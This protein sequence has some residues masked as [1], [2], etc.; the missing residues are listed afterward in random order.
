M[1]EK[2]LSQIASLLGGEVQGDGS[3][4]ICGVA[5]IEQAKPGDL[6]FVANPRYKKLLKT[7]KA[8]AAIVG[9]D[10]EKSPIPLIRHPNPYF[11]F[12]K[13]I[14]IFFDYQ[15]TYPEKIDPTCIQGKNLKLGKGVFIGPFVVL[16]DDVE[17][18]DKVV[19]LAS[20]YIGDGVLI[21][22]NSFIYPNVT[23][24]EGSVIGKDV[25][26]H[27]GAVI[28]SDGFGYAK[29]G[30]IYHKIPQ[31]GKVVIEDFVEIGANVCVDRATLGE[32]RI[33][34]GTKIDNLVQIAHNVKIGENCIIISQVGISGSSQIGKNVTLAG[35]AGM[36]GHIKIGDNVAVGAQS[37][38]SKDVPPNT[39]IFGYPAREI[40]KAKRIEAC[41][42]NL[43]RWAQRIKE[44]EEKVEKLEK[45][46]NLQIIKG[47]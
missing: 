21:G 19:V 15:K 28:G 30:G 40:K 25:I 38:I 43:P 44:L 42:S 5:G 45:E 20:C 23:I 34:K 12:S 33:G 36:V 7:T 11:A 9:K 6:T 37:G 2:T 14:Q 16:G 18:G 4:K 13:A 41:V 3:I 31:V 29:E 46:V 24:R 22:E 32:T 27:S 47:G 26:I 10:I 8:S 39:T 17:I 1:K 35:Q